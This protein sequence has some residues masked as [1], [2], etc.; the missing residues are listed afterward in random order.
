MSLP[1]PS[2]PGSL[3]FKMGGSEPKKGRVTGRTII[4][5]PVPQTPCTL[6][7][8]RGDGRKGGLNRNSLFPK[9][10]FVT[11]GVFKILFGVIKIL[12]GVIQEER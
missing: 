8:E 9:V 7:F 2:R 1:S 3:V 11:F 12:F 6:A 4:L 5:P 10:I